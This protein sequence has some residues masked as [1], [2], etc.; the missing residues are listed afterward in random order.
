MLGRLLPIA[1]FVF[2]ASVCWAQVRIHIPGLTDRKDTCRHNGKVEDVSELARRIEIVP[3]SSGAVFV[4]LVS[5]GNTLVVRRNRSANYI[6]FRLVLSVKFSGDDGPFRTVCSFAWASG[7]PVTLAAVSPNSSPGSVWRVELF[8]GGSKLQRETAQTFDMFRLPGSSFEADWTTYP[9]QWN[10]AEGY[11]CLK[12]S[13]DEMFPED[14]RGGRFGKRVRL[15]LD[16]AQPDTVLSKAQ[17]AALYDVL[18]RS[19]G[20]WTTACVRCRPEHLGVVRLGGLLYIRDGFRR[21]IDELKGI[22]RGLPDGDE[23]EDRLLNLLRPIVF[24]RAGDPELPEIRRKEFVKYVR[25][26]DNSLAE[27]CG[28]PLNR[29]QAPTAFALVEALC[30]PEKLLP[31]AIARIRIRFRNDRMG[32]GLTPSNIGCTSDRE[33]T[34]YNVR[35]FRF[36]LEV[37]ALPPIGTGRIEI[38]LA[39]AVLHEMG[40]WIGLPHI[41]GG[42]SIMASGYDLSRC[43]DAGALRGLSKIDAS[44]VDEALPSAFTLWTKRAKPRWS[45]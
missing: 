34:E 17:N 28:L 36:G 6:P 37:G 35:D 29:Q 22:F 16:A 45:K 42:E 9:D 39:H 12:G 2:A 32:C 25:V 5:G 40:H 8:L 4:A 31:S 23:S 27:I 11:L 13:V 30:R 38:S 26:E 10:E 21:W 20:L 44:G 19:V 43:I 24:L 14:V 33:L 3:Q 1:V 15:D 18:L 7:A 41:D